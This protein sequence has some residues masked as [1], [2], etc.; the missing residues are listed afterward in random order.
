MTIVMKITTVNRNGFDKAI[1]YAFVATP[2]AEALEAWCEDGLCYLGLCLDSREN[3]VADMKRRFRKSTFRET[4]APERYDG[5]VAERICL[6]GTEF[7]CGVWRELLNIPRGDRISYGELA[8]RVG[9]SAGM[10]VRAVGQ[11]V[12]ANPIGLIVPCHRVVG[13]DGSMHG[14]YWGTEIKRRI[15]DDEADAL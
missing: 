5:A 15:L 10:G 1:E 3:A 12:G 13:A 11:A 6:V 4:V 7:Q 8:R 9:R 14:Y 2:Y